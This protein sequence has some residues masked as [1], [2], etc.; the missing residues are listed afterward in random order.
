M[1]IPQKI[2]I[3]LLFDPAIPLLSKYPKEMKLASQRNTYTH[4]SIIYNSIKTTQVPVSRYVDKENVV[5]IIKYYLA[6]RQ[7]GNFVIC[8]NMDQ[9]GEYHAK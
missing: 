2:K 4:A 9:L 6:L 8:N 1:K 5:I 7:E 3:E